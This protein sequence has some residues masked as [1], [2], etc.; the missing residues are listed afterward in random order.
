M[1][2]AAERAANLPD[3]VEGATASGDVQWN[4]AVPRPPPHSGKPCSAF[5]RAI[6]PPAAASR[7]SAIDINMDLGVFMTATPLRRFLDPKIIAYTDSSKR[8]TSVTGAVFLESEKISVGMRLRD[9]DGHLNTALQGELA[10]VFGALVRLQGLDRVEDV[11]TP[12]I[13]RE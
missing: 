8:N 12:Q 5:R 10:G 9:H 7:R 6:E 2:F 4:G 1:S 3:E 11:T 13:V